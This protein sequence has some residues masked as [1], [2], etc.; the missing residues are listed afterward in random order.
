MLV[1]YD[2]NI[3]PLFQ[4]VQSGRSF[5]TNGKHPY[6]YQLGLK[7]ISPHTLLILILLIYTTSGMAI[8][9]TTLFKEG[10]T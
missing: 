1:G 4:I 6:G 2:I 10:D 3:V 9:V 8:M 7:I 5:P